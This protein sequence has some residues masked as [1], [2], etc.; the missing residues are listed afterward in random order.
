MGDS[1]SR[2]PEYGGFL[3]LELNNTGEMFGK[4]EPHVKRFNSVKAAFQYLTDN[5]VVKEMYIPYYYCPSTIDA[6][7]RMG[8]KVHFYHIGNDLLPADVEDKEGI[9]F[10]PVNYF[11]VRTEEINLLAKKFRNAVVLIDRAHAFF[12]EPVFGD[13]VY[14]V[15]SA[16]KFF[17]IP[18]GAYLVGK[19]IQESKK[20][21]SLSSEYSG[22]LLTTYEEGTNKTYQM[23][24]QSDRYIEEHY[25]GMSSLA[26]GLLCNV[27]YQR[28]KDVRAKNYAT[29][30]GMLKEKNA[31]SLPDECAAYHYPM[32]IPKTGRIL[33]K[34]LVEQKIY[35]PTLWNG[36]D[37]L[38]DGNGFEL[39]MMEDALF[40]PVDQRYNME[41]MKFIAKEVLSAGE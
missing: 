27:D 18:D 37:L 21:F 23:K 16:K 9:A 35:V 38:K 11:G 40:L 34:R 29:L 36:R 30:H 8:I 22:Y 25:D 31:L 41:D 3:P 4:H 19:D 39:G 13:R 12:D 1:F 15:Y 26:Y 32:Y 28:V 10:M 20:T 14:N 7:V 17:G 5:Q 6:I 24:K 2:K 33:K